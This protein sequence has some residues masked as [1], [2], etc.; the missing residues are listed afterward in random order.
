MN[1]SRAVDVPRVRLV[2][3]WWRRPGTGEPE[4]KGGCGA[5]RLAGLIRDRR[6]MCGHGTPREGRGADL[7]GPGA[8]VEGWGWASF[9]D[10]FM[11]F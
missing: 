9:E 8:G 10:I 5:G 2:G 11:F 7:E 4:A 3:C 1:G 6:A